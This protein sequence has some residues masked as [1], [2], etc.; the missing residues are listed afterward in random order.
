[1][2]CCE[3]AAVT[4]AL[5]LAKLAL[6]TSRDEEEDEA[7]KGGTDSSNDTDATLVED[8]PLGYPTDMPAHVQSPSVLGKRPRNL[9]QQ[10]ATV[11][12]DR[13]SPISPKESDNLII[14]S[15]ANSLSWPESLSPMDDAEP[16]RTTS[17]P[18]QPSPPDNNKDI[19]LSEA[20]VEEQPSKKPPN[21]PPRKTETS[22]S[23]MMFG[24]SHFP[25]KSCLEI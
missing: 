17:P 1:L 8:G 4:P 10:S 24:G 18:A 5:E 12:M 19:T 11:E 14:V 21:L 9:T 25:L 2:E 23:T 20:R 6:V 22:D 3:T 13:S 15:Q 16:N 7:D